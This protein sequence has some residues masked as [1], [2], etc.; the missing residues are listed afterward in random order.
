MLAEITALD[1]THLQKNVGAT[2][3]KYPVLNRIGYGTKPIE[4]MR[5]LSELSEQGTRV[6]AFRTARKGGAT[7]AEAG[8]EAREVSLDF[9]RIGAKM[10]AV[11][12]LIAF[13]NANIQGLDKTVRAFKDNP[14]AATLKVGAAITLPSVLLALANH[15]D[16]RWDDIPRWQKDLFW[17]VMPNHVSKAKWEKMSS[18]EQAEFSQ[19]NHIWRIPKPFELGIVFG[20]VPERITEAILEKDPS[21]LKGILSAVGRG[22]SPG[23]IPT[24]AVPLVENYSNRSL[25]LDRPLIPANKE[26]LLPEYQYK[27]YTTEAAKAI[28]KLLG[29]LP[30]IKE[31]PSIAPVKIENLIRG[32]SGGL[33]M[34]ILRLASFGFE[35]T[36]V[37]PSQEK[38][39]KTLSDIPVIKAFHVRFPSSGSESVNDFYDSYFSAKKRVDTANHLIKKEFNPQEALKLIVN[40]EQNII[41]LDGIYKGISNAHKTLRILNNNPDMNEDEKRQLIDRIYFDMIKMARIGNK[42]LKRIKSDLKDAREK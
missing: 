30:P 35:K 18:A 42:T 14:V 11:N 26:N 41:K 5:V 29:K 8:F 24:V 31:N 28:G 33:G 16:G 13:S 38:P 37:L 19:N 10:R 6:G 9:S 2:L 21:N 25:F 39:K 22:A 17:I 36:G 20:T 7:L 34:H 4:M 23:V 27:T 15:D 1:R 40:N 3:S 12:S 32:W